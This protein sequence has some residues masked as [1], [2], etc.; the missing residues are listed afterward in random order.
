[1]YFHEMMLFIEI[2]FI[3]SKKKT[4][5]LFDWPVHFER[6][7]LNIK[8]TKEFSNTKIYDLLLQLRLNESFISYTAYSA[9]LHIYFI[10]L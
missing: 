9:H 1:M 2:L 8:E 5:C 7:K 4:Q 6:K 3:Q 10:T